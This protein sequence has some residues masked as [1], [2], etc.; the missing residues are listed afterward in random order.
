MSAYTSFPFKNT[1][2]SRVHPMFTFFVCVLSEVIVV[3]N[4]A[5]ARFGSG[6]GRPYSRLRFTSPFRSVLIVFHS[7][8]APGISLDRGSLPFGSSEN[9]ERHQFRTSPRSPSSRF[10]AGT[11]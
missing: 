2:S 5:T 3:F 1:H 8:E 11:V 4:H 10:L 9:V 7:C 6:R